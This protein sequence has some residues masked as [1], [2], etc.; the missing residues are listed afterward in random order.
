MIPLAGHLAFFPFFSSFAIVICIGA[1]CLRCVRVHSYSAVKL[2]SFYLLNRMLCC[3]GRA[4]LRVEYVTLHD[5]AL[6]V[7]NVSYT[8]ALFRTKSVRAI[9]R[10]RSLLQLSLFF[11]TLTELF[12]NSELV[13]QS[14][15][16][17]VLCPSFFLHCQTASSPSTPQ[18]KLN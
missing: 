14:I 11:I 5:T 2:V 13:F 7:Q 8:T 6:V 18:P 1:F 10:V 9:Q 16:V 3:V 15:F 12:F 4:V 17:L